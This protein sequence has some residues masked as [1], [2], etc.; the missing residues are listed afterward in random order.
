MA[1]TVLAEGPT[2]KVQTSHVPIY[3]PGCCTIILWIQVVTDAFVAIFPN[4][5]PLT[6]NLPNGV[7][8]LTMVRDKVYGDFLQTDVRVSLANIS[9][10]SRFG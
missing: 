3:K 4:N 6:L 8:K 2:R 1:T 10:P 5:I 7:A 9:P